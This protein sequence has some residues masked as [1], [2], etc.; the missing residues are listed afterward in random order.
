[1]AISGFIF[2]YLFFKFLT[3]TL[4][5]RVCFSEQQNIFVLIQKIIRPGNIVTKH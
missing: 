4:N 3:L 5:T 2:I 1:M